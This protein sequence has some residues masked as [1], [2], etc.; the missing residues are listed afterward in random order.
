MNQIIYGSGEN[1]TDSGAKIRVYF[2]IIKKDI[3]FYKSWYFP[4]VFDIFFSNISIHTF[5]MN[6]HIIFNFESLVSF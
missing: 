5:Y 2:I 3:Y 4:L 6:F 1:N